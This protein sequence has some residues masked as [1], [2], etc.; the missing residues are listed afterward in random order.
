MTLFCAASG[1]ISG[2]GGDATAEQ[3]PTERAH[4]EQ[5]KDWEEITLELDE[6]Q[7]VAR[8]S[9]AA[10][11]DPASGKISWPAV[12]C[13]LDDC[14][15]RGPNGEVF[16]FPFKIVGATVDANGQI[17]WPQTSRNH[18]VVRC[19]TCGRS[20]GVGHYDPPAVEHRKAELAEELA[21]SRATFKA[22]RRSDQPSPTDHRP[23]KEILDEIA[24]LPRIFLLE[25]E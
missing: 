6:G 17:A 9:G 23:P 8:H 1:C 3:E 5:A 21:L 25:Q 11:V 4:V 14:S 16:V 10:H 18:G 20:D 15:G 7:V 22:A 19:P 13:T 2:C 12:A 24:N